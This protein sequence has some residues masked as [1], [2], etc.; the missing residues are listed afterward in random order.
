MLYA[1]WQ[2]KGEPCGAPNEGH[3]PV[4][5]QLLRAVV[6]DPKV[7]FSFWDTDGGPKLIN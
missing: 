5:R 7:S 2:V 4:P 3:I 6:Y 1:G